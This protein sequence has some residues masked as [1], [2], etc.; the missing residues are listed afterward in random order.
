MLRAIMRHMPEES[1]HFWEHHYWQ[2]LFQVH[3][4]RLSRELER[5]SSSNGLILSRL[6]TMRDARIVSHMSAFMSEIRFLLELE[7]KRADDIEALVLARNL[8]LLKPCSTKRRRSWPAMAIPAAL[9]QRTST[10]GATQ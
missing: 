8:H 3:R 7:R 4:K 6:A 10:T 5:T 2:Q 1:M 9:D